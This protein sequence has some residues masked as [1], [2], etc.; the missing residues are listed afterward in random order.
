[1]SQD[2]WQETSVKSKKHDQPCTK[3][4]IGP[5]ECLV[6]D[7]YVAAGE[8]KEWLQE[9]GV[10]VDKSNTYSTSQKLAKKTNE[11]PDGHSTVFK[12]DEKTGYVVYCYRLN[13]Q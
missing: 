2:N 4:I 10:T 1:M 8:L 5:R 12:V 11:A 13:E 7:S 9:Q 3:P 6:K